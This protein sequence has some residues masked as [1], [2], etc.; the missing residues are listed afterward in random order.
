M[1][2]NLAIMHIYFKK[3]HFMRRERGELY[4]FIDFFS[5]IG[6]VLGLCM[7]FSMLS[8]V[9]AIYFFTLRFLCNKKMKRD[10]DFD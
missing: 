3:L 4:G 8:L 10:E 7:G 9:E 1:R 2:E 5:N 6:G